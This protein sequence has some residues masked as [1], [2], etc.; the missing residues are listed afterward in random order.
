MLENN[1]QSETSFAQK[2]ELDAR[3]FSFCFPYPITFDTMSSQHL[4][5]PVVGIMRSKHDANGDA[6]RKR[7][8]ACHANC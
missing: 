2:S 3:F 1:R 7:G 6:K 4:I 8:F 5:P